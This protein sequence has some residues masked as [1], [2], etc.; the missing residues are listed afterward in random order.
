MER[1]PEANE[2]HTSDPFT[3]VDGSFTD[4]SQGCYRQA[5]TRGIIVVERDNEWF[6]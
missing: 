5:N 3:P 6:L 1:V 2:M 4:G